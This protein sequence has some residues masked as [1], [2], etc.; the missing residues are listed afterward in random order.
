L[1]APLAAGALV[2]LAAATR[3]VTLPWASI[4][5]ALVGNVALGFTAACVMRTRTGEPGATA[6]TAVVLTLM[7]PSL[8]PQVARQVHTFPAAGN[9]GPS[10]DP[11][12]W[13]VLA[14]C[15][16]TIAISVHGPVS[17]VGH[18]VQVSVGRDGAK[19]CPSRVPTGSTTLPRPP[20][21]IRRCRRA[22][23]TSRPAARG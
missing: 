10:S 23:G 4:G 18:L 19:T 14:L 20:Q 17:G 3:G 15:M 1:L 8:L 11:L 5:L 21:P 6:G 13:T 7:A 9:H 12:W 22:I 16:V 2:M